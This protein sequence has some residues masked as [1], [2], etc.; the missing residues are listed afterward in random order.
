[1]KAR[2]ALFT[3][4]VQGGILQ[5]TVQ[6][7][8]T[9]VEEGYDVKVVMPYEIHDTDISLIAKTDLIQYHKEKKVIDQSPYKKIAGRINNIQPEFIWYMDDSVICSNVGMFLKGEIKQLLTLHDAGTHHPTNNRS[10]R[11]VL[12][13]KYTE[14]INRRF[15]KRV[16]KFVLMS[17]ESVVTFG[18]LYPHY[19]EKAV[20]ITLG[21][22]L[23]DANEIKPVEMNA[24]SDYLLF[25][26]RIDKYKGI[27]NLLKVYQDISDKALPLVIA[28]GG[29]F[30][31]E[32]K[33]LINQCN[34]LTVINRYIDDG[35]MKWLLHHMTAAVL[36]YIE[37]TQSGII[38]LAYL[39]GK[40]V[41]V[42][43]VAGLTQFVVNG[44]T[45]IICST[46]NEWKNAL[47]E[48]TSETARAFEKEILEYYSKNMDWNANVRGMLEKIEGENN[49]ADKPEKTQKRMCPLVVYCVVALFLFV[50]VCP[51][52]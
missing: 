4:N 17:P 45:G 8:K 28:G 26:G 34:N 51:S 3:A 12:L 31:E 42:S 6:L 19:K 38:P 13:E 48:M 50:I 20:M 15:Y 29:N 18:N 35:E 24:E 14:F 16:D 41:V 25:F 52:T 9:L 11:M 33:S 23:P 40:P 2:I 47:I 30:T 22:H 39:F 49:N 36:P 5:L 43:N 1:M 32:E 46:Q 37:A 7:Y 21:A 10:L 44:K 27:G